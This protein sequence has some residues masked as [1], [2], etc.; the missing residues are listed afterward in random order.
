MIP[1]SR[2]LTEQAEPEGE[3]PPPGTEGDDTPAAESTPASEE[4]KAMEALLLQ[5]RSREEELRT[6]LVA[7]EERAAALS[8][9]HASREAELKAAFAEDVTQR[10]DAGIG[11]AFDALLCRLEDALTEVLSPFLIREARE[12]AI[13]HL[14]EMLIRELREPDEPVLAVRAPAELHA[15]LE[16]L[17]PQLPVSAALAE[18]DR[19]EIVFT[20]HRLRFE[21]LSSRWCAAIKGEEEP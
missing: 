1:L 17:R 18:S 21:E 16:K 6:A 4:L 9:A 3:Q 8:A 14:R 7:A 15:W 5:L 19:I 11:S 13:T 12:K 2:W 10:L 20:G